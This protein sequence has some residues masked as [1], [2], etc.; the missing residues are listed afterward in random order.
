VNA[1]TWISVVCYGVSTPAA[2]FNAVCC[3]L[4]RQPLRCVTWS[5]LA[6]GYFGL[7]ISHWLVLA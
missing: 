5:V 7:A 4:D 3:A 6:L 2:I 1:A